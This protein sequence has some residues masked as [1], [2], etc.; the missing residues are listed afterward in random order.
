MRK[1]TEILCD[2]FVTNISHVLTVL[3]VNEKQRSFR[4]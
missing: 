3:Q 2:V 4:I 1:Y